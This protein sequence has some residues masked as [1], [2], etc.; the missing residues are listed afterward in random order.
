MTFVADLY[1]ERG[2]W[3]TDTAYI[4]ASND[5][6]TVCF[7]ASHAGETVRFKSA[8]HADTLR[9]DENGAVE[10]SEKLIEEGALLITIERY[11]DGKCFSV[12][13]VDPLTLKIEGETVAAF[14]WIVDI[15]RRL[16]DIENAIFGQSSP[17]FE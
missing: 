5:P 11:I 10:V 1:I 3:R 16:T 2:I 6:I 12:W 9:L 8:R 17:L 15:E 4:F 14:P 13:K 7:G